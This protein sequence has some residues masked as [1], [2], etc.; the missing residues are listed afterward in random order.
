V[1]IKQVGRELGVRYVLEGSVRRSGGRVRITGQLI[2]SGTGA[3]L[4][5]DH[6]DGSAE[7]VFDLQDR[8]TASVVA[9]LF[10]SVQIGEEERASRKPTGNLD[11]YDYYLRGISSSWKLT[12]EG[13]ETALA[14]F[15]KAVELDD[16]FA[17]A[18]AMLSNVCSFRKQIRVNTADETIK[19]IYHARRSLE[20]GRDD[21]FV[22]VMAGFT[23]AYMADEVKFGADCIAR[24]LSMNPNLA[25]GWLFSG[26]VNS[27]LGNGE[28]ALDHLAQAERL[29]PRDRA[30]PMIRLASAFA[31]FVAGQYD[32]AIR[33]GEMIASEFPAVL[34]A[35]RVQAISYGLSG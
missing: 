30:L 10:S 18:H 27:Y 9:Q 22:L 24:G 3:H 32:E 23:L 34:G 29:S 19:A 26:W 8:V 31:H 33:L 28:V 2:D 17:L 12:K 20:L 21:G 16:K 7:D 5:A 11:A 14:L 4:W 6:F 13:S 15:C 1:D 25:S 35:W